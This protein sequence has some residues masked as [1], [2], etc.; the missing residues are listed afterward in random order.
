MNA[1]GDPRAARLGADAAL[2]SVAIL[3]GSAFVAQGLAARR[4]IAYLYNG[5]SFLLAAA[6]LVPLA[7]RRLRMAPAPLSS[8][9]LRRLALVSAA[10]GAILFAATALQQVGLLDTELANAG[11]LT[12]L[13]SVITPFL[14]W[15]LFR[16][17]PA[18]LDLVAVL[19]AALGAWLLSTGGAG[20]RA[21]PGDA[22][23]LAGA[24]F[25]ALHFVA[26][27]KL[28]SSLDTLAYAAG[29]F[30]V[31]G[32]LNLGLGLIVE[33]AAVLLE[34]PVALA[35]LYR[36]ILSIGVGYTV[37]VWGQ[38][39]TPPTDAALIL[40]LE[41]VFAAAAGWLALGQALSPPRVA[42]CAAI[43]AGVAVAQMKAPLARMRGSRPGR[44]SRP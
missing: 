4:G 14:L 7:I 21:R 30:L 10:T 9:S 23:E 11:F 36:A 27:A 13:Y 16:E 20:L 3:W 33:P 40:G 44:G 24:F 25:W 39:R 12:S 18:S 41:A 17:R 15:I 32:V 19:V 5:A 8:G 35:V 22:F 43:L 42:G 37:Q 29:Q 38:K 26:I 31:C 6:L 34:G 28:G 2:F 1:R